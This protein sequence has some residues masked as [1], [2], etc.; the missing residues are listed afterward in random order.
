MVIPV[1]TSFGPPRPPNPT[2]TQPWPAWQ[3]PEPRPYPQYMAP[4]ISEP[5]E[6]RYLNIRW[7]PSE[8][9]RTAAKALNHRLFI[10]PVVFSFESDRLTALY[11][12]I[13]TSAIQWMEEFGPVLIIRMWRWTG[14][15][16]PGGRG[17]IVD[18]FVGRH[19][20]RD[21]ETVSLPVPIGGISTRDYS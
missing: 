7:Y 19:G 21:R 1:R 12:P 13:I 14:W 8:S 11:R 20:L 17:L 16:A 4:P 18:M 2:H 15:W 9:I 10:P 3:D 5:D 6:S